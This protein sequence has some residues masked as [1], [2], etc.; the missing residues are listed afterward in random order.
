MDQYC[1][2]GRI[3]EGAH[4]IVF[5][6]KHVEV[7]LTAGAAG[8]FLIGFHSFLSVRCAWCSDPG[9]DPCV[10][11]SASFLFL[12]CALH[13]NLF[14]GWDRDVQV[15]A[16]CPLPVMLQWS[17]RECPLGACSECFWAVCPVLRLLSPRLAMI[18]LQ[19]AL[20]E[21]SIFTR[22]SGLCVAPGGHFLGSLAHLSQQRMG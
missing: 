19:D 2:L 5:K 15:V 6:A 7:S 20:R 9:W 17:F 1:I 8:A 13:F 16:S 12:V 4:G 3:G 18:S 21:L 14:K 10:G 11:L 22:A